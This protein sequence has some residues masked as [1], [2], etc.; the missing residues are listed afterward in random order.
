MDENMISEFQKKIGQTFLWHELNVPDAE[1]ALEFYTTILGMT[2]VPMD[3]GEMGTYHL[4]QKDGISIAG[5]MSTA[6]MPMEVAPQW[7]VYIA[8]EDVDAKVEEAVSKGASVK[9][10][11]MD[12]PGVGRM[13][14]MADPQGASFWFFTPSPSA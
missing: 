9:I 5:I 2:T 13:A 4:L 3:M 8:V 11:A 12:V 10:P 1:K 14:W 7:A 6:A